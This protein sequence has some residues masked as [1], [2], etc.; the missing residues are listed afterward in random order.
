MVCPESCPYRSL[1]TTP[2]RNLTN[3]LSLGKPLVQACIWS[4]TRGFIQVGNLTDLLNVRKLSSNG[5]LFSFQ[6]NSHWWTAFLIPCVNSASESV[7]ISLD[8]RTPHWEETPTSVKKASNRTMTFLPIREAIQVKISIFA[9]KVAKAF[10]GEPSWVCTPPQKK[11]IWGKTL[12]ILWMRKAS[13]SDRFLWY[14]G[15]L[16]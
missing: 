13:V 16:T 12:W 5:H 3:A 10:G 11:T 6:E 8:V 9:L 7:H 2:M 14:T 1:S 4:P 15:E